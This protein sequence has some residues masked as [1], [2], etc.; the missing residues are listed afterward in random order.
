[1]H[2]GRIEDLRAAAGVIAGRSIPGVWMLV[3]PGSARVREEAE[4]EGLDAVFAAGVPNGACPAA[5]C[6]WP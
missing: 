5:P 2:N 4:A 3:V 6:V 1:M